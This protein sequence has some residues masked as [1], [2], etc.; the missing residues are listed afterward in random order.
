MNVGDGGTKKTSGAKGSG[1]FAVRHFSLKTGLTECERRNIAH[2]NIT[3]IAVSDSATVVAGVR[4]LVPDAA[5]VIVMER[6][7]DDGSCRLT[8]KT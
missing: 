2:P 8:A 1:S 4:V 5:A 6:Q 7:W 3:V